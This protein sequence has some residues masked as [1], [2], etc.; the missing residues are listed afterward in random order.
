MAALRPTIFPRLRKHCK[1]EE[2]RREQRWTTHEYAIDLKE[3][4]VSVTRHTLREFDGSLIG[5]FS[6][7]H[8]GTCPRC[9]GDVSDYAHPCWESSGSNPM[10]K[11]KPGRL[12]VCFRV[13]LQ[14]Q[15]VTRETRK[16]E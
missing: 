13:G 5:S 8:P 6:H 1:A 7:D 9:P 12:A 16:D 4:H 14:G 2:E 11:S 15:Y 10:P 3:T